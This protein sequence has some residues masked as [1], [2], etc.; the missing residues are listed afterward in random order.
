MIHIP[1]S[2]IIFL[3]ITIG[4]FALRELY[5][6][7]QRTDL[8]KI[9]NP[10]PKI[11]KLIIPKYKDLFTTYSNAE[12]N[13]RN[14]IGGKVRNPLSGRFK[15]YDEHHPLWMEGLDPQHTTTNE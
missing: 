11:P 5:R 8:S 14:R 12:I 3:T 9:E 13:H 7:Y 15:I 2:F 6:D 4:F 1:E 10:F